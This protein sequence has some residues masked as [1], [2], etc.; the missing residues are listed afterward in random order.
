MKARE[1]KEETFYQL[2]SQGKF[3]QGENKIGDQSLQEKRQEVT[4]KLK[5]GEI[6]LAELK[7]AKQ[8]LFGRDC[9]TQRRIIELTPEVWERLILSN[10]WGRHWSFFYRLIVFRLEI[11]IIKESHLRGY[12]LR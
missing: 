2:C 1:Y 5:D 12:E 9:Y 3:L 4:A 8:N 11:W 6:A 7:L 10:H